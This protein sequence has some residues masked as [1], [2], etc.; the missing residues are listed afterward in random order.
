MTLVDVHLFRKSIIGGENLVNFLNDLLYIAAS[1]EVKDNEKV[2]PL[3]TMNCIKNI[4]GDNRTNHQNHYYYMACICAKKEKLL[5]TMMQFK[6]KKLR[7]ALYLQF[8]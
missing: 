3:V 4:I 1:L 8:L 7:K 5:I 6:K 2:H